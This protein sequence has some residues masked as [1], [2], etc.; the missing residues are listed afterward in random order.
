MSG[1]FLIKESIL[2]P[3]IEVSLSPARSLIF[4]DKMEACHNYGWG[5]HII[6]PSNGH[7]T[8]KQRVPSGSLFWD[9]SLVPL[10]NEG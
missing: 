1:H 9:F 2:Y 5:L 4:P 8:D 6:C 10:K 3:F 7:S